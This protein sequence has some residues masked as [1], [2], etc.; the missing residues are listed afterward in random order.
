MDYFQKITLEELRVTLN[1]NFENGDKVHSI[2][3]LMNGL[4]KGTTKVIIVH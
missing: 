1:R 3:P 2:V 4:I